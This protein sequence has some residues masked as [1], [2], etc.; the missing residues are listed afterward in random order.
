MNT[1]VY[2][3]REETRLITELSRSQL[4][5]SQQLH[6][7]K[8]LYDENVPYHNFVHALKVAEGVLLLPKEQY[9]II[10]IQSLFISALFHDAGK[11][12]TFSI[13]NERIH[14][15]NHASESKKILQNVCK[16]LNVPKR[17][18]EKL[19]YLVGHHMMMGD[20]KML[21]NVIFFSL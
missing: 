10:E 14:F 13:D 7:I 17:R 4:I 2:K 9:N 18:A 20:F 12:T 11:A 8:K 5:S 21:K 1:P 19:A 6:E 15:N 16:R 3:S